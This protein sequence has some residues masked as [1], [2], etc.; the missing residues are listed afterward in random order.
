[1]ILRQAAPFPPIP[2]TMKILIV[3]CISYDSEATRPPRL[4]SRDMKMMTGLCISYDSLTLGLDQIL[5]ETV[6]VQNRCCAMG[7]AVGCA[8]V[9]RVFLVTFHW[10]EFGEL[11]WIHANT[12]T[13]KYI[14]KPTN[15]NKYHR[16][17]EETSK[18]DLRP[19]P[20]A[21]PKGCARVVQGIFR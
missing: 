19:P 3:R 18:S 7:C 6:C 5:L 9:V 16:T 15:M 20:I 11:I 17:F 14:A 8:G 10:L 4:T 12:N 13:S 2:K 1:M 21:Q